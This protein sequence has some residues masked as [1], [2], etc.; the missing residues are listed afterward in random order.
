[1][2]VR[3]GANIPSRSTSSSRQAWPGQ[4]R[5]MKAGVVA[6]LR[7][8]VSREESYVLSGTKQVFP[9]TYYVQDWCKWLG[10]SQEGARLQLHL[11]LLAA[12]LATASAVR[13]MMP[14]ISISLFLIACE[15]LHLSTCLLA[16]RFPPSGNCLSPSFPH[17]SY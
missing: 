15:V 10:G 1:M 3:L 6:L 5:D 4:A 13:R 11:C 8:S 14:P 9:S 17:F 7:L 2:G 12:E 16:I